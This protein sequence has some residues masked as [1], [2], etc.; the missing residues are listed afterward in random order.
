MTSTM[1]TETR[2][3]PFSPMQQTTRTTTTIQL[4][5]LKT[6]RMPSLTW[7]TRWRRAGV[8]RAEIAEITP[9]TADRGLA[10]TVAMGDAYYRFYREAPDYFSA[11]TKA[12][13]AMAEAEE[14]QA[15]DMLCSKNELMQLM[16]AA[17]HKGLEDGTMSRERIASPAQ[18][19]LYLRG[20]LH[21]VI[22]LCQAEAGENPDFPA[23]NLIHHT[24]DMLTRSIAS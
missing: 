22:M 18:T 24:M 8:W 4:L 23:D 1:L 13:T 21:G 20:A 12:S 9:S 15:L 11:L 16:E 7:Q 14:D 10:R 6:C 17:I 5:P 2:L 3:L 19:A